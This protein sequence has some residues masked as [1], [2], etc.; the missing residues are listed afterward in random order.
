MKNL[1]FTIIIIFTFQSCKKNETSISPEIKNITESIYASGVIKS[2]NQYEVFSKTNGIIDKFFVKEGMFVKKGD[3]ICQIDNKNSKFS[4]ENA[5]LSNELN[6]LSLNKQKL[7]DALNNSQLAKKKLIN[8]SLLY[9]RQVN[10]WKENIGT[11]VELEQKELIY[12]NSKVAYEHSKIIYDDLNRQ[13]NFAYNQSKNNLESAKLLEND[14]IIRSKVDGL[15]YKINKEE[16]ELVSN[17]SPLAIIGSQDFI[18]ELNIDE[19]DIVKLK[20][21]QEV[22]IRMDAYKSQVFEAKIVSIIPMMNEKTRTF[23]A[24]AIFTNKPHTLYPNLTLEAN[25]LIQTKQN[26]LTLPRNYLINDSIVILESGDKQVIKT[27]LMDYNTVEIIGGLTP[28]SKII[29]PTK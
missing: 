5:R 23:K 25:I 8:D 13:L 20:I 27:G 29:S 18:I 11:K 6:N 2:T 15:V 26:I 22:F 7:N 24:H 12:E 14:L 19:I 21:D 10:L 3:P 4:T 28:N 16:G 9:V 1:Y 17:I